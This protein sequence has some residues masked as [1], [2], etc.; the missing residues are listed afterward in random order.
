VYEMM[1]HWKRV[2]EPDSHGEDSSNGLWLFKENG[3][4][5]LSTPKLISAYWLVRCASV[6]N[7][8]FSSLALL[9]K[10]SESCD[11][12]SGWSARCFGHAS[13]QYYLDQCFLKFNEHMNHLSIVLKDCF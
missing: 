1:S 10:D 12:C 3:K 6:S 7:G 9:S 4:H 5:L 8:G 13:V 11:Y 2:I